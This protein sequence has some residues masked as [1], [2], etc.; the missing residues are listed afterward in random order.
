MGDAGEPVNAVVGKMDM[1]AGMPDGSEQPPQRLSDVENALTVLQ[2]EAG[3][4]EDTLKVL[5]KAV[6]DNLTTAPVDDGSGCV[7]KRPFKPSSSKRQQL[8]AE[9][10]AE[11][12]RPLPHCSKSCWARCGGGEGLTVPIG[13]DLQ[14]AATAWQGRDVATREHAALQGG[15]T[16]VR[17]DAQDHPRRVERPLVGGGYPAAVD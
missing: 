14:V 13:A 9:E 1:T 6:T 15:C 17:C 2:R 8:T 12:R 7:R 11:V 3:L 10:A 4:N 5:R 16:Q